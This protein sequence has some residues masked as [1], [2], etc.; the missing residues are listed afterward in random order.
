MH[1]YISISSN[2][3][4]NLNFKTKNP[5]AKPF[6]VN[7]IFSP[8]ETQFQMSLHFKTKIIEIINI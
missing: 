2:I 1:Y 4:L 5:K 6:D 3:S 8:S 7:Q